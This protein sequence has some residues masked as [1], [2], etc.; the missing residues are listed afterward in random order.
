[1][2]ITTGLQVNLKQ[3]KNTKDFIPNLV[4]QIFLICKEDKS[5]SLKDK[6]KHV[7]E[8]LEIL[9][10]KISKQDTLLEQARALKETIN[11]KIISINEDSFRIKA[12]L[13]ESLGSEL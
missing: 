2:K 12:V 7:D 1:M 11:S 10:T 3:L 13:L 6:V 8:K 4:D 5:F 9:K